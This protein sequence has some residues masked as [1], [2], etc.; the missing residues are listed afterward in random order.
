MIDRINYILDKRGWTPAELAERVGVQPLAVC[1]WLRGSNPSE[2]FYEELTILY[3]QVKEAE[4]RQNLS[5]HTKGR[6]LSQRGK[7]RFLFPWYSH[8]KK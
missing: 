6:V 7:I 2:H 5:S 1:R 3:L 8:Q 4:K